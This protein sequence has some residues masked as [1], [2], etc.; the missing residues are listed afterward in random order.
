MDKIQNLQVGLERLKKQLV[1]LKST[2]ERLVKISH[3]CFE[4]GFT[5]EVLVEQDCRVVICPNCGTKNDFWL[6]GET[7][8]DCHIADADQQE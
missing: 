3:R 5:G 8:P 7:P 2:L 1:K 6:E 4:C